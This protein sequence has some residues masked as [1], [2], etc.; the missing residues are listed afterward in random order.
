[1]ARLQ[2]A[3]YKH[4]RHFHAGQFS[5][6]KLIQIV[7]HLAMQKNYIHNSFNQYSSPCFILALQLKNDKVFSFLEKKKHVKIASEDDEIDSFVLFMPAF[8][9]KLYI[10]DIKQEFRKREMQEKRQTELSARVSKEPMQARLFAN[11]KPIR[12]NANKTENQ[13]S[14]NDNKSNP[15]IIIETPKI[16]NHNRQS[17]SEISQDTLQTTSTAISP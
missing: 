10:E 17:N 2:H 4:Q 11:L 14:N 1:M 8:H 5:K 16:K 9:R 12:K 6:G 3:Q 7:L 13:H 15:V